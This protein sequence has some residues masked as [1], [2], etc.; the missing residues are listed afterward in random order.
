MERELYTVEPIKAE[1]IIQAWKIV[2]PKGRA[3][4]GFTTHREA[5]IIADFFNEEGKP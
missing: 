1:S 4:M 5:Q 2:S 3:L